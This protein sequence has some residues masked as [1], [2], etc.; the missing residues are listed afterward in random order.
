MLS[1]APQVQSPAAFALGPGNTASKIKV[2]NA[3]SRVSANDAE[4]WLAQLSDPVILANAQSGCDPTGA[5]ESTAAI[6]ACIDTMALLATG[7]KVILRGTYLVD[8]LNG[9]SKVSFDMSGGA[10]LNFKAHTTSHN[11]VIRV[12]DATTAVNN[13]KIIGGEINGNSA[14]QTFAAE[15]WSHGVFIWG[16]D[17]N[18]I[19]GV[20]I[21]DCKGDCIAIG[22][23]T[24]RVVGSNRNRVNGCE[25]YNPSASPARMACSITYGNE[26]RITF[27]RCSGVI[28]LELNAGVGECKNNLVL[29][30]TGRTQTENLTGPRTSDLMIA[31]ASLNTD[32]MRYYGNI[33]QDNHCYFINLQYA[34]KC[35]IANNV[36]TGSNTVQTRLMDISGCDDTMVTG[37]QFDVN[38]AV[39]TNI[40]DVIRTR[41]CAV[42]QVTCNMVRGDSTTRPFHNFIN[43]FG[44]STASDHIFLGNQTES[45]W[46][47]NGACQQ[48][49]ER[50][51]F[52]ID[53]TNGGSLTA[54]QIS[55][56]KCNLTISRSGLN[57]VVSQVGNCGTQYLI[58]LDAQCNATTAAATSMTHSVSYT[59]TLS[60]SNRTVT[61]FTFAPA[62]G[63]VSL[64]AFSF[65]AAGNTGTFFMDVVF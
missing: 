16:S 18:L 51:R 8:T 25:L 46:Y 62:A 29:G 56:A 20:K 65:A 3:A 38:F 60:G 2:L 33:A 23:D 41:G 5:V 15:E 53:I 7:G 17:D 63:A 10:L 43:A 30:N 22:Y 52:R 13:F 6:Q 37:N 58:M 45:G 24:G 36:I 4:T 35:V 49:T 57:F 40:T 11:P 19:D 9:K 44:A 28:D 59:Y 1:L 50:A 27:N 39:A 14:G 61:V 47:R 64:A 34:K 32:P 42:L 48:P 54:A 31:M 26:N 21:H 55:G 12:G